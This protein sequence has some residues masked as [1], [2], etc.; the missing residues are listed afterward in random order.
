MEG[1][2]QR[3]KE[4]IKIWLISYATTYIE[5]ATLALSVLCYDTL[6]NTP[7]ENFCLI[8]NFFFYKSYRYILN[9]RAHFI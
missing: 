5:L 9:H 8:T 4:S 6:N 2:N 3:N 7:I 1:L